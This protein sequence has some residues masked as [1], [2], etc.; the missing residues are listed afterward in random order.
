MMSKALQTV[1][2]ITDGGAFCAD[3]VSYLRPEKDRN[4]KPGLHVLADRQR[5]RAHRCIETKSLFPELN[6][7]VKEWL[8]AGSDKPNKER[9]DEL[10]KR[11][12]E[13]INK[14]WAPYG[15]ELPFAIEVKED[16]TADYMVYRA[17]ADYLLVN[18]IKPK[19]EITLSNG[20]KMNYL[21]KVRGAR[22]IENRSVNHLLSLAFP[23]EVAFDNCATIEE[24]TVGVKEYQKANN[25]ADPFTPGDVRF[26]PNI[27]IPNPYRGKKAATFK[28]LERLEKGAEKHKKRFKE[29]HYTEE[30]QAVQIQEYIQHGKTLTKVTPPELYKAKPTEEK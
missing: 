7:S 28:E 20:E 25:P 27:Y 17:K 16:H 13:H 29:A 4:R 2:S 26:V 11:V 18:P 15:L 5:L 1:Q 10:N 12:M 24:K 21:Y 14:F 3:K 23:G 19:H 8:L 30:I 9:V 6:C 22:S